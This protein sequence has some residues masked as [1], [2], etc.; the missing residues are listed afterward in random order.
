MGKK[1]RFLKMKLLHETLEILVHE[2][3]PG[4]PSFYQNGNLQ[5]PKLYQAFLQAVG[6]AL[7]E[8]TNPVDGRGSY[9]ATNGIKILVDFNVCTETPKCV[10]GDGRQEVIR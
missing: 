4:P 8:L 6:E 10:E 1:F 3:R 7:G 5:L 9:T 2:P